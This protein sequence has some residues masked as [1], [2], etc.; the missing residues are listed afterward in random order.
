M[1]AKQIK[2]LEKLAKKCQ[3]LGIIRIK[4]TEIELE[5]SPLAIDPPQKKFK[6][7]I[8]ESQAPQYSDEDMMFWSSGQQPTQDE[9]Q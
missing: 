7:I 8:V 2:E 1:D 6:E 5:F 3:K 4:T 9:A